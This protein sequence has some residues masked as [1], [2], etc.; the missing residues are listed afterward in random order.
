MPNVQLENQL[1][2]YRLQMILQTTCHYSFFLVLKASQEL[3]QH[4]F[5]L[6]YVTF[7]GKHPQISP[8]AT[9]FIAQFQ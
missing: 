7:F 6:C 1:T 3:L 9:N 2:E 8:T 5:S 4:A